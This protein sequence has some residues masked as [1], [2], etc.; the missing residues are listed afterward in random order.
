MK[1]HFYIDKTLLKRAFSLSIGDNYDY[2][3]NCY[4][5]EVHLI[6]FTIHLGLKRKK[7]LRLKGGKSGS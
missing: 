7:Q 2:D 3:G 4:G 1:L 6:F 5:I